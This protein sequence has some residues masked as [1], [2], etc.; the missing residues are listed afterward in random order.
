MMVPT[1]LKRL[2]KEGGNICEQEK[3][4][5]IDS[6]REVWKQLT[7]DGEKRC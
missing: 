1:K 7:V 3:V 2:S 5:E 4:K 6:N